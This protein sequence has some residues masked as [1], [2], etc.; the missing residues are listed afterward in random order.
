M[1]LLSLL[2]ASHGTGARSSPDARLALTFAVAASAE[3]L[4]QP[5]GGGETGSGQRV[6]SGGDTAVPTKSLFGQMLCGTSLTPALRRQML[7]GLCGFQARLN[8]VVCSRLTKAI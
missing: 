7:V 1:L 2:P 8:Y 6:A 5:W 4:P 3:S